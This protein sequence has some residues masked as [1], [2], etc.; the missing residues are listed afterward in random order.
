MKKWSST[1]IHVGANSDVDSALDDFSTIVGNQEDV[2]WRQS[3]STADE[4]VMEFITDSIRTDGKVLLE[5][6]LPGEEA[7]MLV[8]MDGSGYVCLPAS[9]DHKREFEGDKAEILAEWAH[10][11]LLQF[12]RIQ[13]R[14]KPSKVVDLAQKL[15]VP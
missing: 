8:V 13:S 14:K 1:A 7:S 4:M 3:C 5:A 9:Q 15:L 12:A 2:C 10:M 11:L 6:F